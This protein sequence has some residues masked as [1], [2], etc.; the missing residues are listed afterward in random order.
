MSNLVNESSVQWKFVEMLDT[1]WGWQRLRAG[2]KVAA[3][4]QQSFSSYGE[5]VRDAVKAGFSPRTQHYVVT[6]RRGATTQYE[7]IH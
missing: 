7:V 4:S 2:G 6:N 5:A 1:Q 3:I